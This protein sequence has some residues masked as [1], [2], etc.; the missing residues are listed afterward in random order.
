MED[1][2]PDLAEQDIA[3]AEQGLAVSVDYPL[4][5]HDL[6]TDTRP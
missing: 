5:V 6:H 3:M 2:V 4:D 1:T